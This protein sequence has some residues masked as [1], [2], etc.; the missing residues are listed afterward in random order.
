[1][2]VETRAASDLNDLP[3]DVFELADQGLEVESLT[4]GHGIAKMAASCCLTGSCTCSS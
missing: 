4:A 1:M 2:D 3:V